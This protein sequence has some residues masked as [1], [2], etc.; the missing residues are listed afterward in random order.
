MKSIHSNKWLYF[1]G[2]LGGALYG[3]DTGVISGAILFMKKELGLNA[4]TEGLVVSSLL[5]GAILGSGFAGKLTDRFGRRKAIMGAALLFC[6][7]GLGVAFAP[8]T[9]VMVLFRIILG[10]A[11]GT[12]TTIVPLY[13]SELAP[14][15]KRGALSSLNQ[16]MITVGILVSYIVNYI[17]ADA[18]AWR[19]MLGLAVVPSVI[20]LIGILFMPE[21][22]RWLFTIGKEEKAREI[23]SS[24]RGTK[25]I[26][27]EID[28]MKEAEKENEGGLKELFE[29][30]VRPALIAGLGLAFLQQ[31]IGTNTII[32]Y[33]P[34]TFTSVGFGNSASILGTGGIGAVNVIM[35]LAAIKVIDKIGRKPLLLAG[36]AGMV[37]SLLVLAAVNL[38]FEHSA[39][40]SWT[41]VICLG[42][43][44]I[45]FAVSWGPAVWVMLPE[46]FPLHVRGIGTGV[47]TLMLH[48][49]TLI[50]SLT[51]PMLMEAV[52]ISYLFL[53]YAAIGILAF[54]FVRF[55]VTETKGKSLEE[56]EQDLKSRNGGSGSESNR[57]TVHP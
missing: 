18:G 17:F 21:S 44:I 48:A 47:S 53:I 36:N 46:L 37:I 54:L 52:G 33:A 2:A 20:L 50:V 56:I 35:T 10:L 45:V 34:K 15:H 29:P 40:A 23:L 19:W 26:D 12:S 57:R 6:I 9:E 43:F 31:F 30:W 55:K 38:F 25:N 4:F 5:A 32:Y 16:L 11:V 39:A 3:Y 28:Q 22:P 24:L 8:N 42:L 14:K 1:F 13:L 7:G 49:G 41:T 51:Y 27:D